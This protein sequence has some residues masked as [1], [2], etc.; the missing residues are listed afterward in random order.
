MT[1]EV[2]AHTNSDQIN[3]VHVCVSHPPPSSATTTAL[4]G[5]LS[6]LDAF[7][8]VA[9]AVPLLPEKSIDVKQQKNLVS[10]P[11]RRSI[12]SINRASRQHPSTVNSI[13]S[14]PSLTAVTKR[15]RTVHNDCE[16]KRRESIRDGFAKLY[17]RV[18]QYGMYQNKNE[19]KD[20]RGADDDNADILKV[21][22]RSLDD[23]QGPLLLIASSKAGR[24]PSILT[25]SQNATENGS[26][27]QASAMVSN[28]RQPSTVSYPSL[29]KMEI[30]RGGAEL[31][32]RLQASIKALNVEIQDL[33]NRQQVEKEKGTTSN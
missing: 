31:I 27:L 1:K 19:L 24:R 18:V 16:R 12:S 21:K 2:S 4:C 33:K 11:R 14:T 29:S 25:C 20:S 32:R 5:L 23:G 28:E 30:L 3:S 15:R 13:V 6:S 26:L 7:A 10:A 17:A 8:S 22:R 9:T